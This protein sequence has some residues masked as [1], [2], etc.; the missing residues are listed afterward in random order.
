MVHTPATNTFLALKAHFTQK[1]P[2]LLVPLRNLNI[3]FFDQRKQSAASV[4]VLVICV[5][6]STTVA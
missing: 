6:Q 1:N 3:A 2:D 4:L 5:I